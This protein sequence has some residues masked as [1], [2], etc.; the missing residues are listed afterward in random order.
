MQ[1]NKV[2]IFTLAFVLVLT[3]L[4]GYVFSELGNDELAIKEFSYLEEIHGFR[5]YKTRE[6]EFQNYEKINV[7]YEVA[8][9]EQTDGYVRYENK[10]VATD[11]ENKTILNK[12]SEEELGVSQIDSP[13]IFFEN[14]I[15][16]PEEGF[17]EGTYTI[18]IFIT[19]TL[20]NEE[21]EHREKFSV[22]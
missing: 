7:Y 20:T 4:I 2:W 3:F 9:L 22:K 10:L 14:T 12:T 8:G 15:E 17:E 13:V 11:P 6:P 21:V 5:D 16:P 18:E 1:I 19:D